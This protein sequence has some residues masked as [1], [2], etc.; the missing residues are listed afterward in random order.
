MANIK[1]GTDGWRAIID[2]DFTFD[3][4]K[5]ASLAIAKYCYD[6]FEQDK[7]ILIGYDPR[8]SAEKFASFTAEIIANFGLE[9]VLSD[10]IVATPVLAYAAKYYNA[11]AIMFTASHNPP[12]YLG[13]K[14]IPDYAGPATDEITK[15]IFENIDADLSSYNSAPKT[16]QTQSFEDVYI[17]HLNTIIDLDKIKESKLKINYDGLHG[18]A[19]GIFTRILKE[20]SIEFN[21]INLEPDGNFGGKMPDPKEKYLPELKEMCKKSGLIG[22]SNDGDGDRFGVFAENGEFIPA[23]NII[24]ILLKHLK[25]NKNYTGKLVKTVGTSSMQDI[26]AHKLGI[27]VVETAVGFKWVGKAMREDDVI[28]GGEE[29]GGLSIK[30]HIPEKDGVIANL[31]IIEAIIYSGK[32]LFELNQ[33]LNDI[34]GVRFINEIVN[35]KLESTKEQDLIIDKFS[36]L[37]SLAGL[38]IKNKNPLDGLK[39][40]LEDDL[41]WA[42]I[43]KSGTEPLLRIYLESDS[44]EKMAKLKDSVQEIAKN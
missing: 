3:N 24:A 18:A 40:Y 4:V 11:N 13:M 23:N 37:N 34:V 29:S 27:D 8:N 12:E 7:K 44:T 2:E 17:D 15:E 36:T 39:L 32:K 20:N 38:K 26:F 42:L 5:K 31:L 10:K 6:N 35:I 30:G 25:E 16:Y 1:F 19:A 33:E 21:A 14:F 22:L 41:S 28:I 43:R 9:V